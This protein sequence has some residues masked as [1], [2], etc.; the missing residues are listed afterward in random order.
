M[1]ARM[2]LEHMALYGAADTLAFPE[3]YR[4]YRFGSVLAGGNSAPAAAKCAGL[5]G[6]RWPTLIGTPR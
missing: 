4:C 3:E 2:T 1:L 5:T 6:W